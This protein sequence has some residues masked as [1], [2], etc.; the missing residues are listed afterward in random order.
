[1]YFA[2]MWLNASAKDDRKRERRQFKIEKSRHR[3]KMRRSHEIENT[4]RSSAITRAPSD[5]MSDNDKTPV[6]KRR[7]T[8]SIIKYPDG[9]IETRETVT[10]IIP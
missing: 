3:D 2:A 4:V 5:Y 9:T 6:R 7:R 1:M 8:R 10:E